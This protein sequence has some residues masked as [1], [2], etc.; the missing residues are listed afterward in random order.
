MGDIMETEDLVG[1]QD[2]V[3]EAKR[4]KPQPEKHS[5]SQLLD[6]MEGDHAPDCRMW[7]CVR[8][9]QGPKGIY[10]PTSSCN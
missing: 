5:A 7:R 2:L 9:F 3:V 4:A 8:A 6:N 1:D 10:I